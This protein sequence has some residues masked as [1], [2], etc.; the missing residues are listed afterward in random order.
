MLL[1]V[2]LN[3]SFPDLGLTLV[4]LLSV[5]PSAPGSGIPLYL[6]LVLWPC[7][8]LL[9]GKVHLTWLLVGPLSCLGHI[10]SIGY[11]NASFASI[12]YGGADHFNAAASDFSRRGPTTSFCACIS[13]RGHSPS[14]SRSFLSDFMSCECLKLVSNL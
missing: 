1:R 9:L 14:Y 10:W 2:S 12:D 4:L 7:R 5:A 6:Q 8:W 3:C 11:T 13:F